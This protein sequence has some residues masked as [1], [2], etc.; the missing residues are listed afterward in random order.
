MGKSRFTFTL[1][2][3][4][5]GWKAPFP[6]MGLN[7]WVQPSKMG[8]S[9]GPLLGK[10]MSVYLVGVGCGGCLKVSPFLSFAPREQ[11]TVHGGLVCWTVGAEEW[12]WVTPFFISICCMNR[13]NRGPKWGSLHHPW[14]P[15]STT[16]LYC[17]NSEL[18]CWF[19]V[20][21]FRGS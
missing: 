6:R 5:L 7:S 19:H 9:L 18:P 2:P 17:F 21:T 13:A 11:Q 15:G 8:V 4:H 14:A 10:H 16:S 20:Y 12:F 1:S 3:G